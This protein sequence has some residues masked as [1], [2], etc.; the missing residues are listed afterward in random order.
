LENGESDNE[1]LDASNGR[2][3]RKPS[4]SKEDS[5]N[6]LALRE[7]E[8]SKLRYYFAIA[9]LDSASVAEK[10]YNELDGIE[11]EHSSMALDLRFVPNDVSFEERK[12]RDR[13]VGSLSASYAPPEGFVV[14]ALQ[15]SGMMIVL[16]SIAMFINCKSCVLSENEC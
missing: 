5:I 11:F 10:L 2:E 16:L 1:D 4:T 6:A 13:Y 3:V 9:V 14:N 12:V 7:Y 15:V 8:L